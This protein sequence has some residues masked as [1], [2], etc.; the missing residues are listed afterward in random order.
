MI[1]FE[2]LAALTLL[3]LYLPSSH[4]KMDDSD[5]LAIDTICLFAYNEYRKTFGYKIDHGIKRSFGSSNICATQSFF[6]FA[7]RMNFLRVV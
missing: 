3:F 1:R 7:R 6:S 4:G 2:S 5:G